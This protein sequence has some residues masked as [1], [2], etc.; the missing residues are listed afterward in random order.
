MTD[1]SG[2]A[3]GGFW[4]R[5]LAYL[6]DTVIL[7]CVLLSIA[8]LGP[9]LGPVGAMLIG[10]VC[11]FLPLLYWGLMQ[12]SKR[13][14]TF[15]KAL[16]GLKVTGLDG[17]RLSIMRSLGR[18]LA[19]YVSAIPLMIGFVVAAFTGRK[20][21]LHDL[22]AST[23]VVREGRGHL[24]PAL[25]IGLL[26]WIAPAGIV[27]ALGA[28]MLAGGMMG[29]LGG[30]LMQQ[31]PPEPG[32]RQVV[33]AAPRKIPPKAPAPATRRTVVKSVAA[34]SPTSAPAAK[35]QVAAKAKASMPKPTPA[36]P[37]MKEAAPKTTTK[38]E[39][40]AA[41]ARPVQITQRPAVTPDMPRAKAVRP[42][43]RKRPVDDD[44]RKC[45]EHTKSFDVIR[46]AEPYR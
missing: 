22:I 11:L 19:K 20:Q 43:I 15:G 24:V 45:L 35:T 10:V 16:L 38:V 3:Y 17:G 27:M 8:F 33:R 26:G 28:G 25:L 44:A 1:E 36:A 21:A 46:C 34:P 18:E 4:V 7:T 14:A 13:Q 37:A 23:V 2:T 32:K 39:S 5:F 6:V 40:R 31:A 30:T 29:L 42:A 9:F 41:P 12:A